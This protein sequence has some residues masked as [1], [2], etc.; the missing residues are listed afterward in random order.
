MGNFSGEYQFLL[1]TR[2]D[3]GISGQFRFDDLQ[4]NQ[5]F[6]FAVRR[7]VNRAHSTAAQP[8]DNFVAAS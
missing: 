7:F 6:D 5:T 3:V 2:E 8:T 1:E 4:C